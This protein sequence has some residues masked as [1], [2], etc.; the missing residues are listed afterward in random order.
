MERVVYWSTPLTFFLNHLPKLTSYL[1]DGFL[2]TRIFILTARWI[3]EVL[4]QAEAVLRVPPK[5]HVDESRQLPALA[6]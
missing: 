1:L 3:V 6:P 2:F 5:K 4:L